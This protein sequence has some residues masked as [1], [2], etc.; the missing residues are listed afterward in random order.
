MSRRT[1]SSRVGPP[2][3]P[4]RSST[5]V[6]GSALP[7]DTGPAFASDVTARR[8]A[9]PAPRSRDGPLGE[10][11]GLGAMDGER[12]PRVPDVEQREALPVQQAPDPGAYGQLSLGAVRPKCPRVGERDPQVKTLSIAI[13]P[14]HGGPDQPAV[15][16]QRQVDARIPQD[17]GGEREP[18]VAFDHLQDPVTGVAL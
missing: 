17:L 1:A 13:D 4:S 9:R 8:L 15:R 12:G 14:R 3:R 16:E 7:M 2:S 11:P 18:V 5:R 10:S 6:T